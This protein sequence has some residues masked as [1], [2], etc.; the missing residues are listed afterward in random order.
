MIIYFI[1]SFSSSHRP[2]NHLCS[3]DVD[4]ELG[5]E[6]Q[7]TNAM[8]FYNGTVF[9]QAPAIFKSSCKLTITYF[10]YDQHEC[11]LQFGPWTYLGNEVVMK[12]TAG[13]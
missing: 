11:K 3:A 6:I 13:A 1:L 9:W 8:V 10:P 4:K 2:T 7:L 12:K 5:N